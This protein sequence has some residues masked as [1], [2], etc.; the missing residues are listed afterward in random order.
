MSPYQLIY[1]RLSRVK[2][3]YDFIKDDLRFGFGLIK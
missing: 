3:T 2:I 1:Y